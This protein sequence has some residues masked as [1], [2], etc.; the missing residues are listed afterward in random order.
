MN[1]QIKP[2]E[3]DHILYIAAA[4]QKLGWRKPASQYEKYLEE[5]NAGTR[6]V[7]V[8]FLDDE[9]AGYLTVVWMT[10]YPGFCE[11]GIPEIAD[12]NVLPHLRRK[13][14]GGALMDSAETLIATRSNRVGIGVGMNSDY[15]SAQRMYAKRGYVPDGRGLS[16]DNRTLAYGDIVTVDDSLVLH[17]IKQLDEYG[18]VSRH[19]GIQIESVTQCN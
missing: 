11:S 1:L 2:L 14:I 8:A 19:E 16:Y 15:G 12:F 3:S 17:L 7:L 6:N 9:F 4:F 13:G 10:D 18:H 5:Q